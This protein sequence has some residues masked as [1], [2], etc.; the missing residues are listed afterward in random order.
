V[1]L[2]HFEHPA[3]AIITDIEEVSV[4]EVVQE[5]RARIVE[6]ARR[7]GLTGWKT[8]IDQYAQ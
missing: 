7:Y 6:W 4:A 8:D 1:A 3:G 2:H 5:L